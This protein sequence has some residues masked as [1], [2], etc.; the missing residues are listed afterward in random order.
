MRLALGAGRWRLVRQLVIESM[1]LAFA[2]GVAGLLLVRW[3]TTL[4]VRF[5]SA[6][7]VSIV[8]DLSPDRS[9][10]MFTLAVSIVTDLLCGT[11]PALRATRVDGAEGL[12]HQGRQQ[13]GSAAWAR[14][15]RTLVVSQ[16]ALCAALLFGT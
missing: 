3:D 1:L 2:G 7:R 16:V 14:P 15:G 11:I 4:L 8:L 12:R 10:L 9:V 6:G 13:A 5:M